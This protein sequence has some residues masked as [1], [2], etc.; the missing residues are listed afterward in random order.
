MLVTA[1]MFAIVHLRCSWMFSIS[2]ARNCL[3]RIWP[4]RSVAILFGPYFYFII[5]HVSDRSVG[6]SVWVPDREKLSRMNVK[7][8]VFFR[9]WP[10]DRF[11]HCQPDWF[12]IQRLWSYVHL[13]WFCWISCLRVKFAS[14][15]EKDEVNV[16]N[17]QR[18]LAQNLHEA[19]KRKSTADQR[20]LDTS[21]IADGR[22]M[23]LLQT[24]LKEKSS[25]L[26]FVFEV[27]APHRRPCWWS[28]TKQRT[29]GLDIFEWN[30]K[31]ADGSQKFRIYHYPQPMEVDSMPL[32]TAE[33][34]LDAFVA[35]NDFNLGIKAAEF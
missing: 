22:I 16:T 17:L 8:L 11:G 3:W 9:F 7:E 28:E 20:F 32:K 4:G 10:P 34:F 21:V 1:A 23:D 13:L 2:A 14:E 27:I 19:G 6:W 26:I 18:I 25:F 35:T 24:L 12:G 30:S 29:Q 31:T 5:S 33:S 15:K